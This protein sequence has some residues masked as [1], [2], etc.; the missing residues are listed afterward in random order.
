MIP[1][2]K[3]HI[4][5]T[6]DNAIPPWPMNTFMTSGDLNNNGRIDLVISGRNG[7]MVWL[8]NQG[9]LTFEEHIIDPDVHQVECGG[10]VYD[11][12]G[13]GYLDVL[14]GSGDSIKAWWWENLG[15]P[16]QA[17]EKHTIYAQ[18]RAG[19]V[20]DTLIGNV[21]SD[22]NPMLVTTN[23][24][25]PEENQTELYVLEFPKQAPEQLW[26]YTVIGTGYAEAMVGADNEFIRLQPEEGLAIGDL[27]GDGKNEIVMGNFWFQ[28]MDG[29]WQAHRYSQGYITTKIALADLDGDGRLEIIL[30][31]GDPVIYGKR[32]GGRLGW[33]K[34]GEDMHAL[35]EEH[36]LDDGL[37]DAHT[38]LTADLTGSGNIDI[39]CGEIGWSDGERNYQRR[40]PWILLYE[41]LGNG[42]FARHILDQGTG[43]HD[44]QLV[45]LTGNGKLDIISKPLHGEN[46]W[47]IVVFEQE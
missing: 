45:D 17:W 21:R 5:A 24:V 22:G 29:Q 2:F 23:Q 27:T 12:N 32:Q 11:I 4:I 7:R 38:L 3:K 41:N 35:W 33:F 20:H 36:L 34:P 37:L 26:P 40:E 9:N 19:H 1:H 42:K 18:E 47:D 15:K 6:I 10:S 13:S 46:I 8:E 44:G 28:Q 30:S 14:V 31:E 43:I 39:L 16:G 25:R